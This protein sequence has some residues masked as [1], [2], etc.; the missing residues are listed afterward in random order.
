MCACMSAR[1]TLLQ[2]QKKKIKKSKASYRIKCSAL[3]KHVLR[4]A[5][6]FSIPLEK[7]TM[8]PT[9]TPSTGYLKEKE[10]PG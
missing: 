9:C 6:E 1:Y 2:L 8:V 3:K 5:E 7:Y 4:R 10:G